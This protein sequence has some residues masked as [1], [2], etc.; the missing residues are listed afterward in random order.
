MGSRVRRTLSVTA[1]LAGCALALWS[2]GRADAREPQDRLLGVF[3]FRTD[4]VSEAAYDGIRDG[5]R[6]ARMQPA[7]VER[8]AGGD[9]G[10]AHAA[11]LEFS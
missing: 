7:T 9:E 3:T 5:L 11:L 6:L 2:N 1:V 4:P 10:A 8:T